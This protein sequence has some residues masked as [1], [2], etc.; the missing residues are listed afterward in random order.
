M[1]LGT[2]TIDTHIRRVAPGFAAATGLS[3]IVLGLF[4]DWTLLSKCITCSFA[5]LALTTASYGFLFL[6]DEGISPKS[7]SPNDLDGAQTIQ[8]P[9]ENLAWHANRRIRSFFGSGRIIKFDDYR[10]WRKKNPMI[11]SC[12]ITQSRELLGFFDVFPLTDKAGV[13]LKSGKIGETDLAI[14]DILPASKNDG[15]N[16]IYIAT[17]FSCFRNPAL[18]AGLE[19][20]LIKFLRETYPPRSGRWY[21]AVPYTKEGANLAQRNGFIL[22]TNKKMN[23]AKIDVYSLDTSRAA[24]VVHRIFGRKY[25]VKSRTALL[26]MRKVA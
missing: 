12:Y 18:R 5:Y 26:P 21:L 15:A 7:I 20:Q 22:E 10:K 13:A 4:N 17:I 25:R 2:E 1:K 23:L 6:K 19:Q 8:N 11:F 9:E 3:S 24:E 16:Y 14:N